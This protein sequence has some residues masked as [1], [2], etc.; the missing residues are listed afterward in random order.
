MKHINPKLLLDAIYPIGSIF[1]NTTNT[2]PSTFLG[3]TWESFGSG[4]TLV[5]LDTSQT[6]FDTL[7]ETG[8]SKYLQK[9]S[10]DTQIHSGGSQGLVG[11]M[12]LTNGTNLVT[13]AGGSQF[14]IQNAGTGNS[15]NLQPYIVVNFWKRTA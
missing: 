15:G 5:G 6:E 13:L 2:N 12:G 3:G 10:H 8:G 1:I 9:H 7:E 4:R 11:F 14:G